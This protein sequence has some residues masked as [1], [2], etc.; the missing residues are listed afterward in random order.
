MGVL[1][2][3]DL[4]SLLPTVPICGS[5]LLRGSRCLCHKIGST[6][7]FYQVDCETSNTVHRLTLF[8]RVQF[9]MGLTPTISMTDGA[10]AK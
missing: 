6:G 1:A 4:D 9:S 10:K 5:F 7:S 2:V 3:T 8:E